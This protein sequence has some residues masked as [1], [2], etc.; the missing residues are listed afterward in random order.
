MEFV[1]YR[2]ANFLTFVQ[3][4]KNYPGSVPGEAVEVAGTGLDMGQSKC[5]KH[6]PNL[7]VDLKS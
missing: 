2:T 7:G 1:I 3:I 6:F 5:I 4:T